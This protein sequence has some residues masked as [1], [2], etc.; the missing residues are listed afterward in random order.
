MFSVNR[1][2]VVGTILPTAGGNLESAN[3]ASTALCALFYP[4]FYMTSFISGMLGEG[5][6][7]RKRHS[8]LRDMISKR[9]RARWGP[10]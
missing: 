3:S 4:G 5:L 8:K 9:G 6:G 2:S 7:A 10:S 1:G